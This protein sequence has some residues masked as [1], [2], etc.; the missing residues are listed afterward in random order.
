MPLEAGAVN[1]EKLVMP[2]EVIEGHAKYEDDCG[3]CHESFNKNL[4]KRLCLD[5][6]K[7]VA[8]DV[9]SDQGMHGRDK[10]V[11]NVE[12]K[13]CHH[14]HI[15]R[16]ADIVQF[17]KGLF[18]HTVSDFPLKGAHKVVV[19][20]SCHVANKKY[21]EAP[22][23]CISCHKKQDV[24]GGKLGEKCS[25]CHQQDRWQKNKFDHD[26]TAFKLTGKHQEVSCILCHPGN[27]YK[28]VD[29]QCNQC[30]LLN[31]VHAGKYGEK[32]DKC[33][34][35]KE[36][37]TESFDHDKKTKFALR[38]QHKK[39]KCASCHTDGYEKKLKMTCIS[40]HKKQDKHKGVLGEK[41]EQCHGES[42]WQKHK[43]EHR[44]FEKT[45]CHSCHKVDDV[46]AGRYGEEC[47]SCHVVSKWD[48]SKFN[49]DKA[50]KYP[51]RGKHRDVACLLCHKGPAKDEKGKTKC[52][53]CHALD[54]VHDGKE[55]RDCR[56]CHNPLGWREKV[57]FDHDMSRLPLIGLHAIALC[58]DCHLTTNYGKTPR[59]CVSCHE[60]KDD[61]KLQLGKRCDNCHNPNGWLYSQFDHDAT[62]FKLK[63]SHKKVKCV[64]CHDHVVTKASELGILKSCYSCH[65]KDDLHNGRFGHRCDRC[66]NDR[67]F[68]E[69]NYGNM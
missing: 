11:D 29:K 64:V 40:C 55:G 57:K 68:N 14:E 50:T 35:T 46:H 60:E 48:K 27:K 52:V 19:C 51:L 65:R 26:K 61:H 9:K 18:D 8:A 37:K 31:D 58:E 59:A 49:H 21:R 56:R 63:N 28:G 66:H 67:A 5:C 62:D 16:K 1:W 69:I 36:W 22:N 7:K 6:H 17:N 38:G 39:T 24:H 53:D 25:K 42:Q 15:G 3:K 33:H 44:N 20:S 4:Q 23:Q 45:T 2:G 47:K 34:S 32:C 43:F 10:R 12:C 54:D 13:Q 30:H 41:C